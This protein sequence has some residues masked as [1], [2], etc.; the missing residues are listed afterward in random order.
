MEVTLIS[1]TP[2]PEEI[3]YIAARVCYSNKKGKELLKEASFKSPKDLIKRLFK[4]GHHSVFEHASFTFLIEGISRV[5]S[6]QLV[7]HRIASYSQ[8]SQRYV[9]E[10][11]FSFVVPETIRDNPKLEEKFLEFMKEA[12][13]LYKE[14]VDSGVPPEDARYTL[15]QAI[16]TT[17]VVTM[18]ARE[19]LHF[20]KL[21]CCNRAQWEI[22]KLAK[23]MLKEVKKV[24]P[25]IFEY[26]GPSC[27][28][29]PCPEGEFSCG[30]MEEVKKE[31]TLL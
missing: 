22:R 4:M 13:E 14:L 28:T 19:L 16:T 3:I 10:S 8:R 15:P 26:A 30:K 1:Y 20:F 25:H 2:E 27:L 18:N 6:H 17:I 29:G 7:R 24:A 21:R 23:N 12:R 5:T 11:D 31:F 9:D